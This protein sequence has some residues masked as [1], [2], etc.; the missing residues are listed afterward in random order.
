MKCEELLAAL[1]DYVDGEQ[2]SALC[3]ALQEH[4]ANCN[5]CQIVIDNIRQTI[6]L[7]RAGEA[8]PLPAALH[9][10]L[11]SLLREQWARKFPTASGSQ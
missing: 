9:E 8:V 5:P 11:R 10:H 4:L 3:Q 2:K 1:N 7:Y 6:T